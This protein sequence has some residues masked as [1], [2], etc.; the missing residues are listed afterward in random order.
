MGRSDTTHGISPAGVVTVL[1]IMTVVV[2]VSLP[3]LHD[4]ALREN[5]SDAAVLTRL[6]GQGL[7]QHAEPGADLHDLAE[8]MGLDPRRDDLEWVESGRLLRHHGYLF[9][10]VPGRGEAIVR[11]WP[12]TYG[13]T[14]RTAF[15]F[16][17]EGG[18]FGHDNPGGAWTGPA[19]PPALS[20]EG[21]VA[22][23]L[24]D[25]ELGAF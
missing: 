1:A 8:R 12:W 25:R 14:G 4:F 6:L 19:Q 9:E 21:W 13:E 5:E 16:R 10:L 24:A 17:A 3:R 2:L 23:R 15:V 20:A 22:V 18:V 11:A 7:V